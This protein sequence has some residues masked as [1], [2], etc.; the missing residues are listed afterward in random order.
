MNRED[1]NKL[2][3]TY[4]KK[5]GVITVAKPRK[6]KGVPTLKMKIQGSADH[7]YRRMINARYATREMQGYAQVNYSKL[8]LYKI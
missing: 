2:I 1:L 8:E 3:N 5:G 6:A 4:L 7:S